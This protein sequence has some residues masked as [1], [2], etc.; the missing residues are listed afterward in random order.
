MTTSGHTDMKLYMAAV[1]WDAVVRNQ[2]QDMLV[3][4]RRMDTRPGP[5]Q[6]S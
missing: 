4:R 2:W 3:P 1:K 6:R 5:L